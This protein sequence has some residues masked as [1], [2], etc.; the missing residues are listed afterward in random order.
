[1]RVNLPKIEPCIDCPYPT[2]F[3]V[4]TLSIDRTKEKYAIHCRQCN[5]SWIEEIKVDYD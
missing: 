5:D 2:S 3:M 1:M 4:N